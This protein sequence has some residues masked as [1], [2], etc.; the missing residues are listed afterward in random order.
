M[1][2][3][4]FTD[5][6]FGIY[7]ERC[8]SHERATALW[9]ELARTRRGR[10]VIGHGGPVVAPRRKPVAAVGHLVAVA[11]L[12]GLGEAR[13]DERLLALYDGTSGLVQEYSGIDAGQADTRS[14][15]GAVRF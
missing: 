10:E 12:V 9:G 5:N 15:S 11:A 1:A 14:Q 13:R 6:S 4:K 3:I 7:W 2:A 8:R